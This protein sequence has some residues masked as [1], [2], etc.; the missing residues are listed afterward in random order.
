MQGKE[1]QTEEKS[2]AVNENRH[3]FPRKVVDSLSLEIL[4]NFL[5][6]VLGNWL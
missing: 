1:P 5:D 2:S 4:Q 6:M 3:R